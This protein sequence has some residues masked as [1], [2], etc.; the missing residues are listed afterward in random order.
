M[1][2]GLGLRLSRAL[3]ITGGYKQS[4]SGAD[5]SPIGDSLYSFGLTHALGDRL[6]L[7]MDG[8]MQQQTGLAAAASPDYTASANL[9]MKF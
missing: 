3:Q 2:L 5:G 1:N 6:N 4:L 7:S 8:T 9:G